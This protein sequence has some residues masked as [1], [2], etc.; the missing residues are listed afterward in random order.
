MRYLFL[1]LLAACGSV[2]IDESA[3]FE[4]VQIG[5]TSFSCADAVDGYVKW[6]PP[7]GWFSIMVGQ[8]AEGDCDWSGPFIRDGEV[9][10]PCESLTIVFKYAVGVGVTLNGTSGTTTVPRP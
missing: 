6:T 7:D 3:D 8:C 9:W 5:S 10:A 4:A 2:G 1:A